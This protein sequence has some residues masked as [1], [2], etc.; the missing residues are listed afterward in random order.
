MPGKRASKETSRTPRASVPWDSQRGE[1][2]CGQAGRGGRHRPR[3]G[4]TTGCDALGTGEQE[5]ARE[6][7][8]KLHPQ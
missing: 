5:A 8:W 1:R 4:E 2:R 6:S 7:I 3:R